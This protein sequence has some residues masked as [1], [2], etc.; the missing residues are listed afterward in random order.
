MPQQG[1]NF[2]A[3]VGFISPVDL[4]RHLEG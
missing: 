1:G 2:R 4:G 3:K